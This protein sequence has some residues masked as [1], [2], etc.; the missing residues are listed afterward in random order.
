MAIFRKFRRRMWG[1]VLSTRDPQA[2]CNWINHKVKLKGRKVRFGY[3]ETTS[4]Y[5]VTDQFGTAYFSERIRGFQFYFD[6]V[7]S[8]GITLAKTYFIDKIEYHPGDVVID[9]GANY[10]DLYQYFR[11]IQ[12]D[13]RYISFEPAPREFQCIELNAP[14]MENNNMALSDQVGE[15]DFYISSAGANSSLILP[16]DTYTEIAKVRTT[17][18]DSYLEE[19]NIS[20]IKL[21]KLEAEGAEPEILK[22]AE[23]TLS[24]FEYI[25]VD[26]GEERGVSAE[27]TIEEISNYLISNG[28]E[29]LKLDIKTGMGRALFRNKA[30]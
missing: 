10:A 4:L 20:K 2:A 12:P 9:C 15:L 3:D 16:K 6:G 1:R 13:V 7:K 24:R 27:S 22:G 28:F 30:M 17:T 5:T 14:G 19:K 23:N 25:T 18:L 21:L 29:M 26:G 8:R 11:Y